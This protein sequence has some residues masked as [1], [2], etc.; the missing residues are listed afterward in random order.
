MPPHQSMPAISEGSTP[1]ISFVFSPT[2]S[3]AFSCAFWKHLMMIHSSSDFL[4][5][6]KSDVSLILRSLSFISPLIST[7]IASCSVPSDHVN[8]PSLPLMIRFLS[9]FCNVL[10]LSY[11]FLSSPNFPN[12][13]YY[14]MIKY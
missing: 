5:G 9:A 7:T 12:M 3:C 6:S 4:L 13:I 10:Y 11:I 8:F 1:R 2:I 14:E